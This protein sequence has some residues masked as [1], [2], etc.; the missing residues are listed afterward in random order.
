MNP[1]IKFKEIHIHYHPRIGLPYFHTGKAAIAVG[2]R[3]IAFLVSQR[4]VWRHDF[5]LHGIPCCASISV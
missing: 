5:R 3:D 4:F 2:I 1:Y